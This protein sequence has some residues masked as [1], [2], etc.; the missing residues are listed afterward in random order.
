[1]NTMLLNI[2]IIGSFIG[3][4]CYLTVKAFDEF[5]VFVVFCHSFY[6]SQQVFDD[7]E[8][9]IARLK[10]EGDTAELQQEPSRLDQDLE[11][12]YEPVKSCPFKYGFCRFFFYESSIARMHGQPA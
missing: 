6:C 1:M 5:L 11:K 2:I 10:E 7:Y 12:Y 8:A 4:C 9:E 3:V